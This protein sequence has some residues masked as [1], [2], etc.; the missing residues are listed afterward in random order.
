MTY[1]Q[2]A[3]HIETMKNVF[4]NPIKINWIFDSINERFN[5]YLEQSSQIV[6]L[7]FALVSLSLIV[8]WMRHVNKPHIVSLS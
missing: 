7:I 3:Q 6:K 1:L 4:Q 8:K 5:W 2:E